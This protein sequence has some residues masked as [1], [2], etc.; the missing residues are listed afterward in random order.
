MELSVQAIAEIIGHLP[1]KESKNTDDDAHQNLAAE[2][3]S[4]I[5]NGV[6]NK[7]DIQ[8]M[9]ISMGFQENDIEI[10]F[11]EYE[12]TICTINNTIFY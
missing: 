3:I 10:A 9:L 11:N 12:V 4:E 6:L 1:M 7:T 5:V 2:P 8:T